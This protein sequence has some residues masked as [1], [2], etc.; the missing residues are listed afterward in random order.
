[1][2]TDAVDVAPKLSVTR[3]VT[4]VVPF[5]VYVRL[6]VAAVASSSC[7]SPSRSQA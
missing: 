4:R 1:M 2:V 6:T 5:V 3:T 7:P